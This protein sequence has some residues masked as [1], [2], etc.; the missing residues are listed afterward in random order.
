MIELLGGVRGETAALVAALC[1]AIASVGW[2]R[3]GRQVPPLELNLIKGSI[4]IVLLVVTLALRGDLL[5]G[6]E[7]RAVWLLGV[8]GAVGIGLGDTA[9]FEA[10]NALGARR[11]LL[12][13]MI[14]P[15][16]AGIVAWA[17]LGE[18]LA[19]VAWLGMALTIAG[20]AW[21]VTERVPG[22]GRPASHLLRGIWMGVLAS[23]AQVVGAVLTRAAFAQTS[24]TPLSSALLRMT[25]AV[26][27]VFVW[28]SLSRP[29]PKW[30]IH[31]SRDMWGLVLGATVVGTYLGISLQQFA[32]KYA[33]TG[34]AQ[35]LLSTS[36][37]FILPIAA[38]MG[39]KV[40]V[41]AVAGVVIALAGI[42]MLFG[43]IG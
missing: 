27:T 33:S 11:A 34:V 14:A 38:A 26:L 40:S 29:K 3:A 2:G 22:A 23:M 10:I 24:V 13:T 36:P 17:V 5:V 12:L 42:A 43:I 9:Y 25:A 32:F 19:P 4:A 39:E 1:W 8:G 16:L 35:T 21:V 41:R 7:W 18:K 28:I 37:L 31:R 6:V 30:T 15:P 20:V